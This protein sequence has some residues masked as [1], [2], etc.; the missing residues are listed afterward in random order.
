MGNEWPNE[1]RVRKIKGMQSAMHHK[2]MELAFETDDL[3]AMQRLILRLR[4]SPDFVSQ[5]ARPGETPLS[6][7]VK[8]G[9]LKA[10]K[11]LLKLGAGPECVVS[12]VPLKS[13]TC[14]DPE[15]ERVVTTPILLACYSGDETMVKTLVSNTSRGGVDADEKLARDFLDVVAEGTGTTPLIEAAKGGKMDIVAVFTKYDANPQIRDGKKNWTAAMWARHNGHRHVAEAID[16]RELE[17]EQLR[18]DLEMKAAEPLTMSRRERLDAAVRC[19]AK[20]QA[21]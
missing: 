15:A 8:L 13:K 18:R 19:N 4:L 11:G 6:R 21:S 10:V 16:A 2:N 14:P 1:F 12:T 20:K 3:E 9:D 7:A 17:V 5:R